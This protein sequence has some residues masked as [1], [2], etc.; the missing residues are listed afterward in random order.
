MN[1]LIYDETYEGWL[2]LY[3]CILKDVPPDMAWSILEREL[4]M[5]NINS[6]ANRKWTE[7]D[8]AQIDWYREK[9]YSWRSIAE[10]MH[11]NKGSAQRIYQYYKNKRK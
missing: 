3:I 5:D 6:K 1:G 11:V 9:G 4:N 7:E 10:K 8:I 2:A